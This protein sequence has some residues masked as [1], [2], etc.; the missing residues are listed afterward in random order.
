[1]PNLTSIA[2]SQDLTDKRRANDIMLGQNAPK[3]C[4]IIF[5]YLT[6]RVFKRQ[7]SLE[8]FQLK[9]AENLNFFRLPSLSRRRT[10]MRTADTGNL[11]RT[12]KP[13]K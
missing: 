12:D 10:T 2:F 13:K 7:H 4:S 3:R 9:L 8:I 1:M 11:G 5:R 6:V